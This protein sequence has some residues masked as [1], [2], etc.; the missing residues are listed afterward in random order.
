MADIIKTVSSAFSKTRNAR[1]DYNIVEKGSASLITGIYDQTD[2]A[3]NGFYR[4]PD[5]TGDGETTKLGVIY[6]EVM[7]TPFVTDA[8][9]ESSTNDAASILKTYRFITGEGTNA[10][11]PVGPNGT[12]LE[13][14][15]IRDE[16]NIPQ[17]VVNS[18]GRPSLGNIV[19]ASALGGAIASAPKIWDLIKADTPETAKTSTVDP[20]TGAPI[21]SATEKAAAAVAANIALGKLTDVNDS[22]KGDNFI[23]TYNASSGMWVAK[24]LNEAFGNAIGPV[25]VTGGKG[26]TGGTGGPGGA[27]GSGGSGGT[28][29][30][31]GTA[32]ETPP[33]TE[34]CYPETSYVTYQ[35][36]PAPMKTKSGMILLP[37]LVNTANNEYTQ[38]VNVIGTKG[39][40]LHFHA[41]GAGKKATWRVSAGD[42]SGC[43]APAPGELDTACF[44]PQN[45][46]TVD[47]PAIFNSEVNY[48]E[49]ADFKIKIC[50]TTNICG[51]E[52]LIYS[53]TH[54]E[55]AVS[56]T[57]YTF[58][59]AEILWENTDIAGLLTAYPGQVF[60]AGNPNVKLYL[61][62]IDAEG[63]EYD[64]HF[65]GINHIFGDTFYQVKVAPK[66]STPSTNIP[67]PGPIA[68]K[69]DDGKFPDKA[70]SGG[71]MGA[72]SCPEP[73]PIPG[74][75]GLPG[76]PGSAGTGGSSGGPGTPG[77][78]GADGATSTI[79]IAPTPAQPTVSLESPSAR[80]YTS[81]D[82]ITFTPVALPA[83]SGTTGIAS[84]ATTLLYKI[85]VGAGSFSLSGAAPAG[86]TVTDGGLEYTLAGPLA[87][88]I[89]AAGL[90]QLTP[91]DNSKG[92]IHYTVVL[93]N[94]DG[95]S[96]GTASV[97]VSDQITVTESQ[98]ATAKVCV[99]ASTTG[100]SGKVLVYVNGKYKE[101]TPGFIPWAGTQ[102]ATAT[103]IANGINANVALQN[104]YLPTDPQWLPL[105]VASSLGDTVTISAPQAGGGDFN[106]VTL[107]TEV[108]A[109]F[110]FG[111]CVGTFL[112]GITKTVTDYFAGIQNWNEISGVLTAIAGNVAGAVALN[113]LMPDAGQEQISIPTD[114]DVDVV[115]LYRGRVIK[116]PN[117][118]NGETRTGHPVN[119]AAFSGTWKTQ[120][121][122]NPAWIVYDFITNKKY[123]LGNE[124]NMSVAQEQALLEDIFKIGYYCD[125]QVTTNGTTGPRFST[126]TVITEGTK[127]Q[128]LQQLCSV[129]FGAIVFYNGGLRISYDHLDTTIKLLVNQANAGNFDKSLTSS[130]NFVNKVR[131][132]YIEPANFYTEEVVVAE[133]ATAIE[134]YGERVADVISFGCTNQYQAIR[135]ATWV[136]NSEIEN[137]VNI[138]YTAGLDHY[139]LVPGDIVEFYDSNERNIRRAGRIVSQIGT[140]VVLDSAIN[141]VAGDFFSLTLANGTVHQTTI[142]SII[143][144]NV[145]LTDAPASPA[146]AYATF[147]AA[148]ASQGRRLYKVIKIDEVSTAK[149]SVALQLYSTDKY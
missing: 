134:T 112:G 90:M 29:G 83:A 93:T 128:V 87:D 12:P 109:G 5:I 130:K 48:M 41:A 24:S 135:H 34:T 49:A 141:S 68:V 106:G 100:G 31:G 96:A 27:G 17:P 146:N 119:Y 132:T 6:G 142:A 26:G 144:V 67:Q 131:L 18:D 116:V 21:S 55:T 80:L 75:P 37:T 56:R 97:L 44:V 85:V 108:T 103:A 79:E 11:I 40:R 143:G 114:K 2:P 52:Y 89:T 73:A 62:R 127:L 76:S 58:T 137:S 38:S 50:L 107:L 84:D 118:Y 20:V 45:K 54:T 7:I 148:N 1:I 28:G 104:A 111:D 47:K 74:T 91:A 88:V 70:P 19:L 123:G 120:W 43:P 65:Q 86:V 3:V 13:N 101:L 81:A 46:A 105:F 10:G 39:I 78:V 59:S 92:E 126:N 63:S 77:T 57:S 121:T 30:T 33:V 9:V 129:F 61:S 136:L 36:T 140:S 51:A 98:S 133:N 14:V 117:E 147:I 138:N 94:N 102:T 99:D 95:T 124:F 42:A 64:L 16:N 115:F 145:T 32:G 139:N 53:V 149:F 82:G 110:V 69:L 113:M 122:Q 125:E 60:N 71:G 22:G 15:Y 8:G 23:L 35:N 66:T 25:T 4:K 72:P